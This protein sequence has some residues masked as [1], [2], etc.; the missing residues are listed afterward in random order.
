MG[1]QR[2]ELMIA[3]HHSLGA[4]LARE[5]SPSLPAGDVAAMGDGSVGP[6]QR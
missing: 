1:A 5:A 2:T 6:G 3:E 4:G